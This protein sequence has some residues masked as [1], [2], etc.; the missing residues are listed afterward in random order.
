MFSQLDG[1]AEDCFLMN[2]LLIR[3]KMRAVKDVTLSMAYRFFLMTTIIHHNKKF[4]LHY[5]DERDI[6]ELEL[7]NCHKDGKFQGKYFTLL[8]RM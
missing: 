4:M 6:E 5:C 2:L 8:N 7:R 1:L 3:N